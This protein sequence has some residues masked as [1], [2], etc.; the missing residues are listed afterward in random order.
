M[1]PRGNPGRFLF[2]RTGFLLEI[3]DVPAMGMRMIL[4]FLQMRM[5]V[6]M[7]M[8]DAQM[9]VNV[10][11]DEIVPLQ[12]FGIGQNLLGSPASDHALITAEHMDYIRDF[13]HNV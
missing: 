3:A 1:P 4:M 10:D 9:P 8:L 2:V 13:F 11:M 12:K 6:C 5:V 7:R